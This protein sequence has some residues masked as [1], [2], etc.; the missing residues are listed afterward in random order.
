M[1]KGLG[2]FFRKKVQTKDT[3]Q[4]ISVKNRIKPKNRLSVIAQEKRDIKKYKEFLVELGDNLEQKRGVISDSKRILV[5]AGAGSGKTKVLT[6]RFLHLVKN[7]KVPIQNILAITFTNEAVNEMK[8]RI[9]KELGME[10]ENLRQN[11]KTFHSLGSYILGQDE[12]FDII[13]DSQQRGIIENLMQTFCNNKDVMQS[14]YDYI[15]DNLLEKIKNEDNKKS[16]FPQ[17]KLKPIGF[18][19]KK[20]M[21][22]AGVTVR[23]KSERDIANFLTSL[24]IKWEYEKPVPWVNVPFYPDFT[25]E[26][27]IYIEHWCY[28]KD[29][30][31]FNLIDKK[32]YLKHRAWKEEQFKKH[33]KTLIS[34]EEDEMLDLQKLQERLRDEL[35]LLDKREFVQKNILELLGLSPIYTK[36]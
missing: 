7:K 8:T 21:T 17:V 11:I 9:A 29:T 20:I 27:D 10:I 14:M 34:I 28:N 33:G 31:E 15:K 1:F 3:L 35:K 32:R 19:E 6:K 25:L 36:S 4:K 24:E 22:K 13:D 23:S 18:G 26:N 5:L 2:N 16:G 12:Q 30:P